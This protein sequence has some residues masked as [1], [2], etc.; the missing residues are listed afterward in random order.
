M[1]QQDFGS[2]SDLVSIRNRGVGYRLF[3][4]RR[5]IGTYR[6]QFQTTGLVMNSDVVSKSKMEPY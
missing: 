1:A 2:G 3:L 6:L 5:G 4:Q